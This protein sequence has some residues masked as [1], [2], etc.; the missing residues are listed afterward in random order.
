MNR[1]HTSDDEA[2]T[3]REALLFFKPSALAKSDLLVNLPPPP[4]DLSFR[5]TDNIY[6]ITWRARSAL[7]MKCGINRA[8]MNRLLDREQ[9]LTLQV[10]NST[11]KTKT[12][13]NIYFQQSTLVPLTFE[14]EDH[15]QLYST[16]LPRNTISADLLV[17]SNSLAAH[18][19]AFDEMEKLSIRCQQLYGELP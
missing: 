15:R 6:Y 11:S 4:R 1:V 2:A 7:Y 17:L 9:H 14:E 13:D 16:L 8:L 18:G 10:M 19:L 3:L 12:L 5:P